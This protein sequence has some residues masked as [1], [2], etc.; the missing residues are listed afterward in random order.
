MLSPFSPRKF[1]QL[2][3]CVS[4]VVS[5][6]FLS[7]C[8]STTAKKSPPKVSTQMPTN[9]G[10]PQINDLLDLGGMDIPLGGEITLAHK[11]TRFSPGEWVLIRGKNL[12]TNRLD[13]DGIDVEVKK[14]YGDYV[15]FQVPSK[16][17]P[18]KQHTLTIQNSYGSAK[19]EFD[20]HHYIVATDTDGKTTH[21]IRTNREEKGGVEKDWITL[22]SKAKRP[23]YSLI[24]NDSRFLLHVDLI[25]STIDENKDKR[26]QLT[27][28]TYHLAAADTPQKVASFKTALTSTPIDAVLSKDNT[29]LLLGTQSLSL[30]DVSDTL[31]IKKLSDYE[32]PAN[33]TGATT[34]VDAIFFDN[35]QHIAL[36]ETYQNSVVILDRKNKSALK[37]SQVFPLFPGKNIPL[38]IDLE[39]DPHNEQQFW[40]LVGPNYRLVSGTLKKTYRKLFQ[41]ENHDSGKETVQHLQQI[42]FESGAIVKGKKIDTPKNYASYFVVFGEDGRAYISTTKLDF[43]NLHSK[44]GKEKNLLKKAKRFLWDSASFGRVIAIDTET[45][46]QSKISAGA[47]IYYHLVDVPDIGPVFSLMKFGPAFSFPYLTPNWGVGVKSTGTYTKRKMNK[48]AVFPPYSLGHVDFQY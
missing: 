45:G 30:L 26:F 27:I 48:Y 1:I 11:D 20:T 22:P 8:N 44:E 33:D 23:M 25:D 37:Q 13:I 38:S 18:R 47:G 46:E 35:D 41:K 12:G 7:G 3:T 16:L 14:Y 28:S 32:L 2:L 40:V 43:L 42:S 24:T 19:T 36:L 5:L 31:S 17:S 4:F 10:K 6:A 29:L 9:S 21:L 39:P 34:Y 15:L